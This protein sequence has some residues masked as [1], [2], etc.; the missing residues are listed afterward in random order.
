M[1]A[2]MIA[3]KVGWKD[4]V[5]DWMYSCEEQHPA[6]RIQRDIKKGWHT[7]ELNDAWEAMLATVGRII[8][9]TDHFS[10]CEFFV[11]YQLIID[12]EFD[13]VLFRLLTDIELV[14]FDE[15]A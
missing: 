3:H 11:D 15:T 9:E 1:S 10:N 12:G 6:N 2:L 7:S 14:Y 4:G 8:K 13:P 5:C